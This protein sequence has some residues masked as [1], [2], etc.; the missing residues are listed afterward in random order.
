MAPPESVVKALGIAAKQ[1]NLDMV[2]LLIKA[3]ATVDLSEGR[4]K[5]LTRAKRGKKYC[6]TPCEKPY[7]EIIELLIKSGAK[8]HR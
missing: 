6:E 1:G 5:P 8:A 3:G 7:D 4:F 2:R